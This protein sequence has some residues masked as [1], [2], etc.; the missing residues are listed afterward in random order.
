MGVM[1]AVGNRRGVGA[2][3]NGFNGRLGLKKTSRKYP[4]KHSV[5]RS[6]N[7]LKRSQ[8]LREELERLAFFSSKSKLSMLLLQNQ[9]AKTTL[10]CARCC[11][12]QA[13]RAR[14]CNAK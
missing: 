6:T 9:G 7:P 11:E 1:V 4:P 14:S 2:G 8:M 3:G 12:T 13:L 5:T 10:A